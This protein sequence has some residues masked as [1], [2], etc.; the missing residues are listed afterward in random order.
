MNRTNILREESVLVRPTPDTIRG[1]GGGGQEKCFWVLQLRVLQKF[2]NEKEKLS[3]LPVC[4]IPKQALQN[5][6]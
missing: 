4:G 3:R 5:P 6:F 1:E 2:P